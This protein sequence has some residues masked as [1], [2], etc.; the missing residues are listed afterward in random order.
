MAFCGCMV[1][2][3]ASVALGCDVVLCSGPVER[4]HIGEA[5]NHA[6]SMVLHSPPCASTRVLVVVDSRG[7]LLPHC[8]ATSSGV[9]PRTVKMF[10][11]SWILQG[12]IKYITFTYH[13]FCSL[14]TCRS[15]SSHLSTDTFWGDQQGCLWYL[16]QVCFWS[17]K[18]VRAHI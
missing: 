16:H 17:L 5:A 3:F 18:A 9:L 14:L 1:E 15:L 2:L 10:P 13:L 11:M 12:L 4:K 7:R 6:P 8:C